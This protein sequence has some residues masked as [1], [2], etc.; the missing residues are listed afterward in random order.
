MYPPIDIISTVWT[1]ITT[2]LG[3]YGFV[4]FL[5]PKRKS[6]F[7]NI[8]VYGK[9]LDLPNELSTFWYL[10]TLP[11]RYFMHF[12]L[13][14]C[15]VFVLATYISTRNAINIPS[16]LILFIKQRANNIQTVTG[17]YFTLI[18]MIIQT[19]RRLYE[20]LFITANS[21]AKINIIHYLFG[22]FFYSLAALSTV[23]PILISKQEGISFSLQ[24]ILDQIVS[25]RITLFGFVLFVYVSQAQHRCTSQLASLRK[26]KSGTIISNKYFV[27]AG[28]YFEYVS[29]PH[30]TSEIV[31]YLSILIIQQFGNYYWLQI[32]F[33]VTVN[34]IISALDQHN[35]YKSKYKD[36]PKKRKAIIPFIL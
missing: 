12:Y 19:A 35:W 22:H 32:F 15:P 14:A 18:L 36:Y 25:S 6:L 34:Q 20:T 9:S 17:L 31:I 30:F 3:L 7:R 24:A 16:L 33:L 11:K 13:V 23:V 26:D 29:C 28:G 27:P 21:N 1:L 5:L 2:C 8:Y 10:Y 4:L